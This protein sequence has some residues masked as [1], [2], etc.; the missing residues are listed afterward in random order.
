MTSGTR[1]MLATGAMSRLRLKLSFSYNEVLIVCRSDEEERVAIRRR[2][3]D[4]FGG[5]IGARPWPVLDDER[6]AKPF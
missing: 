6:L 3:H 2:T 4:R 1:V 5:D